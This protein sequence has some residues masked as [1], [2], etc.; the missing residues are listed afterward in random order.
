MQVELKVWADGFDA[1]PATNPKDE[2]KPKATAK[3][4]TLIFGKT[5]GDTVHVRRVMPDGVKADFVPP[6]KI[7]IGT[8]PDAVDL[9]GTLK[10]SRLDLLDPNLH[11]FSPAVATKSTFTGGADHDLDK[12]KQ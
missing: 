2:P 11:T 1:P 12:H 3:P 4:I 5:E 9:V 8:S 7:K 10:K 6:D